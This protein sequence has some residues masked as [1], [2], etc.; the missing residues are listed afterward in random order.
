MAVA[1]DYLPFSDRTLQPL[2]L[3][4]LNFGKSRSGLRRKCAELLPCHCL[5]NEVATCERVFFTPRAADV[6]FHSLRQ[7]FSAPTWRVAVSLL[8]S[9]SY[10]INL[11]NLYLTRSVPLRSKTCFFKEDLANRAT[12]QLKTVKKNKQTAIV[13]T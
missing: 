12:T 2:L 5:P 11:F 4:A 6:V 9:F 10:H 1:E 8:Q 13:S 3:L 7:S